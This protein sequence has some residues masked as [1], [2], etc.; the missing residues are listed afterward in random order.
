MRQ[1]TLIIFFNLL[2]Y[3]SYGQADNKKE[4]TTIVY[5]KWPYIG[6]RV[7][8]YIAITG[9]I[10]TITSHSYLIGLSYSVANYNTARAGFA[11]I[12][13]YYK[14][15]INNKSNYAFETDLCISGGIMAGI[16]YNYNIVNG[17]TINGFKPF[18][19]VALFHVQFYYGYNFYKNSLDTDRYLVHNKF[20]LSFDI[21]T[22]RIGKT[23]PK[24]YNR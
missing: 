11:G 24:K 6:Y 17:K 20:T 7:P 9:G 18:I 15:D 2:L 23:N 21:P 12:R 16:N 5:S 14:Q 1:F 8:N 10:E 13:V 19:G 22:F 4:D 3:C